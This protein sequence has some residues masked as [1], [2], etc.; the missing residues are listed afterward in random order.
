[1]G[2]GFEL[3]S[4]W[5]AK[6]WMSSRRGKEVVASALRWRSRNAEIIHFLASRWACLAIFFSRDTGKFCQEQGANPEIV[7]SATRFGVRDA[8]IGKICRIPRG[9]LSFLKIA[10]LLVVAVLNF[11]TPPPRALQF[12]KNESNAAWIKWRGRL[13]GGRIKAIFCVASE[14]AYRRGYATLLAPWILP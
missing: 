9:L 14:L 4:A 8:V 5:E 1:M 6:K 3:L 7:S 10:L 12:S 11:N 13:W 2:T